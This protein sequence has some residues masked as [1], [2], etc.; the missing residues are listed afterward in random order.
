[1]FLEQTF[2]QLNTM[3]M[4]GLSRALQE[5]LAKEDFNKLAFD[6]RIGM[7]I[8]REYNDRENR[9]LTRRLQQARLREKACV[10]DIDYRHPR[11][12]DKSV[13]NRL[14]TCQWVVK[15]QN[16]IITGLTGVGKTY[17]SCALA[18][19]ACREGYTAMYRRLPRLLYEVL[20]ARADGSYTKMLA[21]IAKTDLL[22]IDDWGLSPIDE[23]QRRDLLE[24]IEDRH[25]SRSTIVT[26]QLPPKKWH[27]YIG[28]PTVAD[29]ILDRLVHNAHKIELKG[30]SIRKT[31]S[32]LD[33]EERADK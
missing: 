11:G 7:L 9:K 27:A 15:H 21:R 29:A 4:Y 12:L 22:V 13:I 10:E 24:V 8:D 17:L 25:Q 28:D 20:Q 23:S 1:M 19:K 5:Q 33:K 16:V 32:S 3:K 26:S 14:S 31:K 18:D 6:E 2:Q 30:E